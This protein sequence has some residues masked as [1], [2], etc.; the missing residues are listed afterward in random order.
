MS[1]MLTSGHSAH[2]ASRFLFHLS[3]YP[4]HPPLLLRLTL[5]DLVKYT[6][7]SYIN[8]NMIYVE[9]VHICGIVVRGVGSLM[10]GVPPATPT[11]RVQFPVYIL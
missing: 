4:P 9:C 7:F 5:V 11:A 1:F 3:L 8:F 2:L 10:V 6:T